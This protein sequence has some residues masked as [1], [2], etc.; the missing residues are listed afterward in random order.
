MRPSRRH[1]LPAAHER[2]QPPCLQRGERAL[3]DRSRGGGGVGRMDDSTTRDSLLLAVLRDVPFD[4]WSGG[5][6]A[7][8][9]RLGLDAAEVATLFPGGARDAVAAFSR[10]ADRELLAGVYA[11]TTLY[12]L[13]DRSPGA[14][15]THAF[16]D[17]RLGD[18][19]AIPR[20]GARLRESLA[21]LPNP[22]RLLHPAR[23]R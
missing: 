1:P 3:P 18:V 10:S 21:R 16:L 19:M 15:D 23:R 2:S 20:Y 22:L 7:A 14:A 6:I 8:G 13:D 17:R 11:A 12:W 4:G 5:M 9:G